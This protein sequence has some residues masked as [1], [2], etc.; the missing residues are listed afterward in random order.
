MPEMKVCTGR[1][2]SERHSKYILARLRAD[3]AKFDKDD[4]IAITECGCQGR[5]SEGPVFYFEKELFTRGNPVKA[6]E[7]FLRKLA[8][9]AKAKKS[10]AQNPEKSPNP[11]KQ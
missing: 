8:E 11:K 5:C 7:V 6:S 10:E 4:K 1:S 3:K 2:C 9:M